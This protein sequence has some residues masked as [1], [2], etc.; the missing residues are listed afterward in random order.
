MSSLK[1][2]CILV[3][4]GF[5]ASVVALAADQRDLIIQKEM[6]CVDQHLH[7]NNAITWRDSCY[8]S[9][10]SL[11][12]PMQIAYQQSNQLQGNINPQMTIHDPVDHNEKD[13]VISDIGPETSYIRYHEYVNGATFMKEK[14]IMSGVNGSF[15]LH[16]SPENPLNLDVLDMYRLEGRFSYG[17]VDYNGSNV[18]KGINDYLGELRLLFGKDFDFNND[19]VRLTPFFGGGYR[20]LF[21]SF[22][23]DKPGGYNRWIQYAYIPT[24]SEVMF[25]MNDGWSIEA[26]GEYDI[27]IY[28]N[29]TSYTKEIGYANLTN[30]QNRGFGLR[31]SLKLVK[32]FGRFNIVLEPFIRYWHIR[33]SNTAQSNIFYING[34]PYVISGY[35]PDNTSTE[36]GGKLGVEF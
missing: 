25:R 3:L 20:S 8:A 18:F 13:K 26:N 14:G 6:D 4:L 5:S 30:T 9:G 12:Q 35:E 28:G 15:T 24:G 22:Y 31:G 7:Q 16:T 1:A 34:I 2:F 21:D 29:V 32:D 11:D 17:Q 10:A 23:E 33:N 27:F 36:V 19:T